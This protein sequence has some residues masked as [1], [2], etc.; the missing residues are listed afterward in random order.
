MVLCVLVHCSGASQPG[1][2][3]LTGKRQ[4]SALI[5]RQ[6]EVSVVWCAMLGYC[7]M[8]VH[9]AGCMDLLIADCILLR[10]AGWQWLY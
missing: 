4:S 8:V 1:C 7:I 2:T 5:K 3:C 10:L 9:K 6:T